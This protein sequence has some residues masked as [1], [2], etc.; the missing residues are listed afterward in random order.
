MSPRVE[1]SHCPYEI[2]ARKRCGRL[3]VPFDFQLRLDL[4]KP[5][6]PWQGLS[7]SRAERHWQGRD[8][9]WTKSD[10]QTYDIRANKSC[11]LCYTE[12]L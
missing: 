4:L 3:N 11:I 5:N 8:L 2:K 6:F 7:M 1:I 12:N 9:Q 10:R